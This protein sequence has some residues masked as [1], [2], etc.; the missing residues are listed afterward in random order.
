MRLPWSRNAVGTVV[1]IH[2]F[3]DT[4]ALWNGVKTRLRTRRWRLNAVN[5]RLAE[6]FEL[7]DPDRRGA[8]LEGYRDQVL[9]VLERIDPTASRP[10]VVV[11]HSMGSQV[12]ELIAAAC[13][14]TVVGLAMIAPIPLGGYALTPA[15]ATQ[16]DRTAHD[17]NADSAARGRR[18]LLSNDSR[19]VMRALVHA[20]LATPTVTAEQQLRAWTTGH[21]LGD[22][23]S[24]VAAPVLLAGGSDD[25]FSSPGLIRNA[26]APRFADV[27]AHQVPDAGHWPHVEQPAVVAQILSCFLSR[28]TARSAQ[29]APNAMNTTE[30]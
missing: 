25:T 11:G 17:R 9:C 15:Q 30:G 20:T 24:V 18:A 2:G 3:Q 27:R 13:P 16:F 26:V 4:A 22:Y 8:I 5:L 1:F 23:P 14:D 10:V 29:P 19:Q 7:A 12:G 6:L 28:L 21:P